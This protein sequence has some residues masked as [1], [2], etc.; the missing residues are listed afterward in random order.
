MENFPNSSVL[1][2]MLMS[3]LGQQPVAPGEPPPLP[4]PPES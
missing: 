2:E 3:A 4:K 1:Y